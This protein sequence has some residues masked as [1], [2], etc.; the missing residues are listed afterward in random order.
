MS[1]KI[2]A[3]TRHQSWLE[4]FLVSYYGHS[5]DFEF[6]MYTT[7]EE[8]CKVRSGIEYLFVCFSGL[9]SKFDQVLAELR[10]IAEVDDFDF[11][12]KSWI[13]KGYRDLKGG[14]S[15][16]LPASHWWWIS[17]QYALSALRTLLLN[18]QYLVFVI[19]HLMCIVLFSSKWR[20]VQ[21]N[22]SRRL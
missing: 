6:Y 4:I 22:G 3:V 15:S 9:N 16:K 21:V 5:I 7:A 20:W 11:A 1:H 19:T 12:L 2:D 14:T 13:D 18:I 17:V 10:E 8:T